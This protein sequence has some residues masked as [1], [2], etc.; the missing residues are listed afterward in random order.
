MPEL[1][2]VETVCRVIRHAVLGKHI[3]RVGVVPDAIVFRGVAPA[4]I[5]KAPVRRT[6]RAV[7]PTR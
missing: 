1:P 3:I 7:G 6:V 2:E 5:E 4:T